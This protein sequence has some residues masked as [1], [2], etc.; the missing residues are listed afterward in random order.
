VLNDGLSQAA[1]NHAV[2]RLGLERE[3][4]SDTGMSVAKK[5]DRL[6]RIVVERPEDP[7]ETV[8]GGMTLAEAV[9][10]EAVQLMR[11]DLVRDAEIAFSRGLARDGY[12]V[13]FDD[14]SR[15]TLRA[16]LPEELGLPAVDNEVHQLLKH[17]GFTT[18]LGHLEQGI[19]A[20][21]RGN[22]PRP[23]R[24]FARSLRGFLMPSLAISRVRRTSRI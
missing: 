24:S 20:H 19:D 12:V 2:L 17:F 23:T 3:I 15:P 8:E 16:A 10:R 5:A 11:P 1:F 21:T 14:R 22:G 9:I 6:G 13:S 4:P 7:V 18:P